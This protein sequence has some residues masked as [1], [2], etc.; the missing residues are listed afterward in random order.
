MQVFKLETFGMSRRKTF[1]ASSTNSAY[2]RFYYPVMYIAGMKMRQ[3]V[4]CSLSCFTWCRAGKIDSNDLLI[5][6]WDTVI[7]CTKSRFVDLFPERQS[8]GT[9]E[10]PL[11]KW[12]R[13]PRDFRCQF[14]LYTNGTFGL[15]PVCD[16]GDPATPSSVLLVNGRWSLL[17]NP[18]CV[19]DRFYD[20][21]TLESYPRIKK[22]WQGTNATVVQRSVIKLKCRLSGHFTGDRLRFREQDQF[23][24]GR[25]SHGSIVVLHDDRKRNQIW[26]RQPRIAA[27]FS[28]K[29]FIASKDALLSYLNDDT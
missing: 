26:W 10:Q 3:L 8:V 18:Y 11:M 2:F 23:A 17:S 21:L 19:T 16:G 14:S 20:D 28:A 12:N 9:E 22:T 27:S 5:G 6:D 24:R 7:R 13:R 4:I 25:L 15:R 1:P 29:R